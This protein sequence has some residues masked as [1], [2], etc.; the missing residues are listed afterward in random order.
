M[1]V[2]VM[3]YCGN[4]YTACSNCYSHFLTRHLKPHPNRID[5]DRSSAD[6]LYVESPLGIHSEPD[7]SQFGV[8]CV[9]MES[10]VQ[11]CWSAFMELYCIYVGKG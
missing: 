1:Q 7:R 5:P 4:S 3:K 10:A 2:A 11:L 8:V 9:K 6:L